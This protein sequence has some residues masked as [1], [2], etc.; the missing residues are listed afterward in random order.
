MRN[1]QKIIDPVAEGIGSWHTEPS[2]YGY[3]TQHRDVQLCRWQEENG[4][5]LAWGA[6]QIRNSLRVSTAESCYT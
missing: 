2:P 6:N 5:A 4:S 1:V 3:Y